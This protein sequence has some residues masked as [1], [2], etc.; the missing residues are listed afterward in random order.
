MAS[1][2][3][4]IRALHPEVA[5]QIESSIAITNLNTVVLELVKN[6]LD[7]D[8]QTITI[9]VDFQKGGCV[10]EDDGVGIPSSEF[11]EEG[12]LGKLYHTSKFDC[13][14][15]VHGRKGI[16]LPSLISLALVTIASR[17]ASRDPTNSVTYHHSSTISKLCPAPKQHELASEHGTKV[18]VTNLFGNLPVRVKHRALTLQRNEDIDKEWDE[19]KRLL[20]GLLIA[21]R[22]TA[23]V[24]LEDASKSRRMIVRGRKERLS[25]SRWPPVALVDDAA[26]DIA[27]IRSI[28]SQV[29]YITPIEPTSWVAASARASG[30]S[31]RSAISLTPSPTKQA[32]FISFGII[33][34]NQQSN[35]NVLYDEINRLFATSNF[36]TEDSSTPEIAEELQEL[37]L[38][39]SRY[40]KEATAEKRHKTRPKGVN[41]WP[42]FYIRIDLKGQ[43]TVTDQ[44]D[45]PLSSE[46]SLEEILNVLNA[47]IRQFLEQYH[48]SRPRHQRDEKRRLEI[49]RLVKKEERLGKRAKSCAATVSHYVG[50]GNSPSVLEGFLNPQ[51]RL[52]IYSGTPNSSS[53]PLVDFANRSKIKAGNNRHIMEEICS[54]LPRKK[55]ISTA[56]HGKSPHNEDEPFR[57][58]NFRPA[59]SLSAPVLM[60]SRVP[61]ESPA[62]AAAIAYS[63]A[64]VPLPTD[65]DLDASQEELKDKVVQWTNPATREV[66]Y[67]NERTGQTL[68]SESIKAISF[69]SPDS[70]PTCQAFS[71]DQSGSPAL[72]PW[73]DSIL[74]KWENP[75]FRASERLIPLIKPC[76]PI[77]PEEEDSGFS[78]RFP[79]V[80]DFHKTLSAFS[81]RLT[82]SGLANAQIVSQVDN[83]FLLLKMSTALSEKGELQSI[84]VL[85]DQHAAD[86]RVCVEQLFSD[87][88]G[89]SS[90]HT[91]D[92][93][94]LPKPI[95]FKVSSQEAQL[96]ESRS[97]YFAS[98]GCHYSVSR[99]HTSLHATV[100]ITALPT[101]I[102]ER[103]RAEPRLAIDMLRSEVWAR[104]DDGIAL[105]PR[106]LSSAHPERPDERDTRAPHWAHSISHCPRGIIDLLNSRACRSAIMFNDKLSRTESEDLIAMLSKCVFPFH[107]AHG[108]PSMVPIINLGPVRHSDGDRVNNIGFFGDAAF[109][110][111]GEH[112]VKK[113]AGFA[114]AYRTWKQTLP[115]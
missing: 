10:V 22:T 5:A 106:D 52:P 60:Q 49:S 112:A 74:Q 30:I 41:K 76:M 35:A 97:E 14:Y 11:R 101:L 43:N 75:A 115:S 85:V 94:F 67:I 45:S 91:V 77:H 48:F 25:Q 66:I 83:K 8:A 12:G 53:F 110:G 90:S 108:R 4:F 1:Q 18:T 17:H 7:A 37:N 32:Q 64:Q 57:D 95:L 63:D 113:E 36:G 46:K 34:L 50:V 81:G 24:T 62:C 100:E 103:C 69:R 89:L 65:E 84:L 20:T 88:C 23:K 61:S 104:N 16:F 70:I 21:S 99:G 68:A 56:S 102:S 2:S 58:G 44:K 33:S 26:L 96:F 59:S 114:K 28:L 31:V 98:W 111:L 109:G 3:P 13:R 19:L 38:R 51:L 93:T 71:R 82:K 78:A 86:E 9:T 40:G 55:G 107:C 42:M 15:E 54:G 80:M 72:T 92:S 105:K 27:R 47:M 73:I 79:N 39:A 6:S 29:G 87:L